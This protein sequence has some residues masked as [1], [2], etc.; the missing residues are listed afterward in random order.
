MNGTFCSKRLN[1][2]SFPINARSLWQLINSLFRSIGLSLA[3]LLRF[4]NIAQPVL[5]VLDPALLDALKRCEKLDTAWSRLL[6]RSWVREL[7]ALGRECDGLDRDESGSGSG[8]K[9][10]VECREFFVWDL[11]AIRY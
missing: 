3:P 11:G 9:D 1:V 4:W 2:P 5:L 7:V 10:L 6:R 8:R